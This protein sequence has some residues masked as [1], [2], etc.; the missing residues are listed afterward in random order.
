MFTCV[1]EG[2]LALSDPAVADPDPLIPPLYY[3]HPPV[4]A[5]EHAPTICYALARCHS[6]T[7][8]VF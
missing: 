4:T 8:S 7:G 1:Q 2:C 3:E 5:I 6:D